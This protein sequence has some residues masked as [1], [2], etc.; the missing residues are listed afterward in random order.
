MKNCL[1]CN[2]EY[3][4]KRP[5]SRFCSDN[6]RVLNYKKNKG[7]PKKN[8]GLSLED[9]IDFIFNKM[10]ELEEKPKI[11]PKKEI[12]NIIEPITK[13]QYYLDKLKTID[14]TSWEETMEFE[15]EV[16]NDIFLTIRE[17]EQIRK[18]ASSL[19]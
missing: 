9:K 12:V 17:K 6:C 8:K 13:I 2:K 3:E 1:N 18:A 5:S 15:K 11:T 19:Q 14:Y 10:I 4:D 7:L 16:S